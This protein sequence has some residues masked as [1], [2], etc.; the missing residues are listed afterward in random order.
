MYIHVYLE[1]ILLRNCNENVIENANTSK[2]Q[3]ARDCTSESTQKG[4][5]KRE[6]EEK[7][8]QKIFYIHISLLFLFLKIGLQADWYLGK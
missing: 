7:N 5:S 1:T 3:Q 8:L 6:G 2:N 4:S